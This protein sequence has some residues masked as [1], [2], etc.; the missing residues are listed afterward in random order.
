MLHTPSLQAARKIIPSGFSTALEALRAVANRIRITTGSK[1][2][3]SI[4]RGTAD[5]VFAFAPVVA[6]VTPT[7]PHHNVQLARGRS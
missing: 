7:A 4:V 3:D 5:I 6:L 2:L 1:V